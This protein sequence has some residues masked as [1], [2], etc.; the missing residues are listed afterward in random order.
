[1]KHIFNFLAKKDRFGRC[2]WTLLK[3]SKTPRVSVFLSDLDGVFGKKIKKNKKNTDFDGIFIKIF[4]IFCSKMCFKISFFLK[5]RDFVP[6][7]QNK[8]YKKVI[9][10]LFLGQKVKK[11]HK[12]HRYGRYFDFF[13]Q[14]TSLVWL[15]WTKKWKNTIMKPYLNKK[16]IKSWFW[17]RILSK[18]SSKTRFRL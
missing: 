17:Y 14:K 9:L 8:K 11:K 15:I 10:N 13:Y 18:K 3:W 7:F 2:F 16:I 5:K 4:F 12:K 6:V 1:M